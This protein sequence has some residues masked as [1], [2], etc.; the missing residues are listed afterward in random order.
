VPG[1]PAGD[2]LDGRPVPPARGFYGVIYGVINGVIYGVINGVIYGVI[3]GVIYGVIYG[4]PA[5]AEVRSCLVADV[6]HG[7]PW[8]RPGFQG[9]TC[10]NMT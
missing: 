4:G 7:H 6:K 1:A 5:R 3:N 2:P 8:G 10:H 9:M